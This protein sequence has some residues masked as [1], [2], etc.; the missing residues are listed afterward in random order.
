ML[1]Y[2]ELSERSL[3]GQ[4]ESLCLSFRSPSSAHLDHI[5]MDLMIHVLYLCFSLLISTS[6]K[7]NP[8]NEPVVIYNNITINELL[9]INWFAPIFSGGGYSSEAISYLT[10]LYPILGSKLFIQQHGI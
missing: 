9:N 1:Y 2:C 10:A 5:T 4:M 7:A 3:N 8:L 6:C